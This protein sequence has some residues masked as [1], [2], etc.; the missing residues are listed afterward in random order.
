MNQP[1]GRSSRAGWALAGLFILAAGLDG[2]DA[3]PGF[4]ESP[5]RKQLAEVETLANSGRPAALQGLVNLLPSLPFTVREAA[6]KA[7]AETFPTETAKILP[8]LLAHPDHRV[9]ER[10]VHLAA[11]LAMPALVAALPRLVRDPAVQVRTALCE[12]W[13]SPAN[14]NRAIVPTWPGGA[15]DQHLAVLAADHD[16]GVRLALAKLAGILGGETGRRLRATLFEDPDEGVFNAAVAAQLTAQVPS[17]R[18]G[19][20]LLAVAR[21]NQAPGRRA[22]AID[23]YGQTLGVDAVPSLLDL[24][25]A[26]PGGRA[27]ELRAAIADAIG[28]VAPPDPALRG[29]C[30]QA[31]LPFAVRDQWWGVRAAATWALMRL[32]HDGVVATVIPTLEREGGDALQELLAGYCRQRQ[33][34]GRAWRLWL[35]GS[36]RSFTGGN[37][38]AIS[39][40]SELSFFKLTDRSRCVALIYQPPNDESGGIGGRARWIDSPEFSGNRTSGESLRLELRNSVM[41]L[42]A[43]SRM[44]LVNSTGGVWPGTPI[45]ATWRNKARLLDAL[46]Q[47]NLAEFQTQAS[48]IPIEIALTRPGAESVL[49]FLGNPSQLA[50]THMQES[51]N[52]VAV[53]NRDRPALARIHLVM[54]WQNKADRRFDPEAERWLAAIAAANSGGLRIIK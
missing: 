48:V 9:R 4:D 52:K 2:S 43:A 6:A 35:N 21:S 22:A 28:L 3:L 11:R 40:E 51:V 25:A 17:Q 14:N 32:G 13:I 45:R 26:N 23:L 16:P 7:L 5:E 37:Q 42:S 49:W 29:R 38:P 31:L 36:G 20:S 34:D 27:V 44:V 10:S 12:T 39:A 54:P 53:L 24:L 1:R 46:D 41:R 8:T 50:H 18:L 47:K 19:E 33:V 15:A 30:I